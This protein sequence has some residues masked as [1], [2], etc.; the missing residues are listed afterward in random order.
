M[1]VPSSLVA[2]S[3]LRLGTHVS[4]ALAKPCPRGRSSKIRARL[5]SPSR[6]ICSASVTTPTS[7]FAPAGNRPRH[8]LRT[9]RRGPCAVACAP[10]DAAAIP[11]SRPG[12]WSPAPVCSLEPALERAADGEAPALP[13]L[14]GTGRA[15]VDRASS[16]PVLGSRRATAARCDR[17]RAR[18]SPSGSRLNRGVLRSA[19]AS[20]AL[21]PVA[22]CAGVS[23]S[24]GRSTSADVGA[25]A[26]CSLLRAR[27]STPNANTPCAASASATHRPSRAAAGRSN[28][29]RLPVRTLQGCT[30]LCFQIVSPTLLSRNTH[31]LARVL[32][33]VTRGTDGRS[34]I[35]IQGSRPVL[36]RTDGRTFANA[37]MWAQAA[38]TCRGAA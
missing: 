29:L 27:F 7:S 33:A 2:G 26:R 31:A 38:T 11:L 17:R 32:A 28:A 5:A 34:P 4:A 16:S 23:R 6:P 37:P 30:R 24:T 3:K 19:S 15:P 36:E 12:E 18:A 13:A 8:G 10:V 14:V 35:S 22:P 25:G 20:A 1:R 9:R 21:S